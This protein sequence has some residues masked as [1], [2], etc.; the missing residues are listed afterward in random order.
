MAVNAGAVVANVLPFSS[1]QTFEDKRGPVAKF[2]VMLNGEKVH[3]EAFCDD[4]KMSAVP[5][6]W[7]E[8]RSAPERVTQS[9]LDAVA[10]LL[11]LLQAQGAFEKEAVQTSATQQPQISQSWSSAAPV[12]GLP[13]FGENDILSDGFKIVNFTASWCVVCASEYALFADL[14]DDVPVYGV[15]YKETVLTPREIYRDGV[16]PFDGIILD[17]TGKISLDYGLYGVPE[18]LLVGPQGVVL[19]RHL[20]PLT[21]DVFSEKFLPLLNGGL[22]PSTRTSLAAASG[23]P[24]TAGER[25]ALRVSIQ[26]CWNVGS[27][28]SEALRTTVVVGVS[29]NEDGRPLAESLR[30]IDYAGG[31]AEDA[32][33]AFESARKAILR[34]GAN[35][36]NLPPDKYNEWR[37]LEMTF[38]PEN[39]RIR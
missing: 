1:V 5:L 23:P 3:L 26:Q 25:D 14:S 20:G 27:L 34:C 19:V 11:L 21:L 10:G 36:F 12:A 22:P 24:M 17:A 39:M 2:R 7:G 30:L 32:A 18:T 4:E 31:A 16:Q 28:S 33:E 9:S 35:G 8:G 15:F 13:S 29:M 38:N 37:E 6:P